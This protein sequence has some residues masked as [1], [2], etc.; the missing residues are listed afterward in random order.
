MTIENLIS[1]LS[2]HSALLTV[3]AIKGGFETS[4][5]D[6]QGLRAHVSLIQ[7]TEHEILAELLKARHAQIEAEKNA[8]KKIIGHHIIGGVKIPVVS[9]D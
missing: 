4:S 8:R 2:N 6:S 9:F 5:I 1:N 3:D 7:E